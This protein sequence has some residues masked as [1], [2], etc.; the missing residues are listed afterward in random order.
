MKLTIIK[1]GG[2]IVENTYLLDKLIN[3]FA[4]IKGHKILVHGGGNMAT[5]MAEKLGIET[6]IF[7]GRRITDV[8]TLEIVTM[9]Y[10][11]LVNKNIVA[12]MQAKGY[13][14]LGITGVD[15]N[16]IEAI[17]RPIEDIDYGLSLIHISEP[18]R[19]Y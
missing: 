19:P 5:N 13:N 18:T 1:V 17:K 4:K 16:I 12:K 11:G 2:K 8:K 6:K 10:A 9:V 7:A 3:V 14:A 15:M